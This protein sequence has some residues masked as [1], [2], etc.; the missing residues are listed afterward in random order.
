MAS[1]PTRVTTRPRPCAGRLRVRFEG[2][3]GL[4]KLAAPNVIWEASFWPNSTLSICVGGT[5]ALAASTTAVSGFSNGAGRW[6]A[7]W[8]EA[9]CCVA[10]H[11]G[12]AIVGMHELS[13]LQTPRLTK[14]TTLPAPDNPCWLVRLPAATCSL[15]LLLSP[16][17]CRNWSGPRL[18][19][20]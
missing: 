10:A 17:C 16:E 13:K 14:P 7:Q 4:A 3:S 11:H 15:L 19:L 2:Y 6:L 20:G 8:T 9:R 5:N 18:V 1:C 12:R